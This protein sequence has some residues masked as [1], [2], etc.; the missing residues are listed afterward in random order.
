MIFTGTIIAA[1]SGSVGGLTF[2]RNRGGA[3]IRVRAV[4]VDPGSA[5]QIVVRNALTTLVTRWGDVLTPAQRELWDVYAT[6]VPV[7]NALGNEIFLT[8]INHYTRSNV[9]RIQAA[10]GI[11]DAA[12]TVFNLGSFTP[13]TLAIAPPLALS[14][15]FDD[16]DEWANE[17]GGFMLIYGS[18]PQAPS[19]NFFKGPY[20]FTETVEGDA[21]TP[22]SSPQIGTLPF[23]FATGQQGFFFTRVSR[24]D[25]RLSSLIRS[26]TVAP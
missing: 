26:S 19:L 18:R 13:P 25:G 5:E 10:V 6:N 23:A 15:T 24:A 7:T 3:Y 11:V 1:A 2:S 4:P 20:R 9:P 21:I 22:P 14:T 17:D 16:T 12:P 8:G